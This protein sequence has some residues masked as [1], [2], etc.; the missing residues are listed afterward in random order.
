[1]QY[2][3]SLKDWTFSFDTTVTT[4]FK[5]HFIEALPSGQVHLHFNKSGNH[6]TWSKTKTYVNGILLGK[7]WISNEGDIDIINHK[8]KETCQIKYVTPPSYF[9]KE[10][11][12]K[13]TAII[14]DSNKYARFILE[15]TITEQ[16]ECSTVMKPK[17]IESHKE[18]S[19]LKLSENKLI[20]KRV[21]P[22]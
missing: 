16:I 8:T 12:N 19:D 4:K 17:N 14:R 21:I 13:I 15:G 11:Q 7:I 6:Y 18:I 5:G 9:S 2:V 10:P 1:M 3:E 20:W 22:P